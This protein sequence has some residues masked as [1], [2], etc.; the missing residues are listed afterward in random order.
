MAFPRSPSTREAYLTRCRKPDREA[1]CRQDGGYNSP[2][3]FT[4][5]C[6]VPFAVFTQAPVHFL[7]VSHGHASTNICAR[8]SCTRLRLT[9]NTPKQDVIIRGVFARDRPLTLSEDD[10][11]AIHPRLRALR[12]GVEVRQNQE[13]YHERCVLCGG[14]AHVL[15]AVSAKAIQHGYRKALGVT[16][17]LGS[18]TFHLS[19]C[20]VCELK[21]FSPREM[22]DQNLY[23][24]LA[25]LDWYYLDE[26]WEYQQATRYIESRDAVLEVG[27]GPGAFAEYV[28]KDRFVGLELNESAVE[29]GRGKGLRI[30]SSLV[31]E[32]SRRGARFN[33]VV[34]FQVLEHAADPR[35]FLEGCLGCLEP[36]GTLI[37]AVPSD[38]SFVGSAVNNWLNMPPHHATRWSDR[39]LKFIADEFDLALVTLVH[40]PIST[41]HERWAVNV[42]WQ[43]RIRR[44]LRRRTPIVDTSLSH[45][46]FAKAGDQLASRIL[47]NLKPDW[48]HTVM[49]VYRN[50]A[51]GR[52]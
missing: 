4:N 6:G 52:R 14:L 5:N 24:K 25:G 21:F 34:G 45:R 43:E 37:L 13:R 31:D 40:E 48:G 16:V 47:R 51:K 20:E 46:F 50:S 26:K 32:Y 23:E 19:Q 10:E 36:D 18:P 8:H 41:F 27:C 49:A 29:R 33:S 2:T 30:E 12:E 42:V 1:L 35:A 39:T 38:D 7:R 11:D 17:E 9:V 22:G 28:G 3:A 44:V 15:E